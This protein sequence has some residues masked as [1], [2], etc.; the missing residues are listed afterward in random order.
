[1]RQ[2]TIFLLIIFGILSCG[3]SPSLVNSPELAKQKYIAERDSYVKPN[4]N[5][6]VVRF[7]NSDLKLFRLVTGIDEIEGAEGLTA[8]IPLKGYECD[9]D[10]PQN[11]DSCTCGNTGFPEADKVDCTFLKI[12]CKDGAFDAN[13]KECSDY[14]DPTNDSTE[15][16]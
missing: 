1:M 12:F 3:K 5:D 6:I 9:H 11:G 15:P 4:E 13:E 7:V 2:V 16:G 14:D 8:L 10:P